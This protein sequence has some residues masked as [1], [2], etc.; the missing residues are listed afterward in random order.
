MKKLVIILSLFLASNL[1]HSQ[2]V[3]VTAAG[4][5]MAIKATRDSAG[6]SAKPTGKTFTDAKGNV[7]PV[8][9]SK[10]GKLFVIRTSKAGN[11]YNQ[12]LKLN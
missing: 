11:K 6:T 7:Y 9:I 4:N 8:M 10:N 12:Y 2:N 1:A 5:Y 3:T